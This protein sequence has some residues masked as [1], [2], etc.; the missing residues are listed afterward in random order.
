[1]PVAGEIFLN[2]AVARF[3]RVLGTLLHNGVPILRVAGDQRA[4]AG[5]RVLGRPFA[6]RRKTSR[7][8]SRWPAAGGESG[9]F[10]SRSPR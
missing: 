1:M 7:Q 5:N 9:I 8:V 3:C 2:L 10:R 6:T 4:A